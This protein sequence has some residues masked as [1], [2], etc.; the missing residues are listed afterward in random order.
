MNPFVRPSG[1]RCSVRSAV[2]RAAALV[3]ALGS[4][5]KDSNTV[6]GLSSTP[7][8]TVV[9]AAPTPLPTTT[10]TPPRTTLPTR[11]PTASPPATPIPTPATIDGHWTGSV[12][13]YDLDYWWPNCTPEATATFSQGPPLHGSPI[14]ADIHTNCVDAAFEGTLQDDG[15]LIGEVTVRSG[16]LHGAASGTFTGRSLFLK[17]PVF[18]G[19]NGSQV[20]GFTLQMHR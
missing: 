13:Y 7:I 19:A 18:P 14:S 6:T 15:T 1:L 10:P 2:V 20:G 17:V 11:A 5:C 9:A 16:A 8:P 4:G 12:A 3:A